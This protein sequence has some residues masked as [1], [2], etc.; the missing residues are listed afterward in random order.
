MS[1]SAPIVILGGGL[2]GLSAAYHLRPLRALVPEREREAGGLARTR[3]EAGF[4]FDC[5]GH[6]LHLR[7]PEI[8]GLVDRILPGAFA[9]HERRALIHSKGVLT[10]YPFQAN[11]HGLPA[12]VV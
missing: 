3:V 7:D 1:E 6:L 9:T 10:A 12:A 8:K 11:L 5:T 2:T 4:T